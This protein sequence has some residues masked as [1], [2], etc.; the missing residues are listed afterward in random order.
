M[1]EN[2]VRTVYGIA[3]QSAK[4]QGLPWAMIPFTTLN[5]K[6][7]IQSGVLPD[8]GVY[9]NAQF[10]CIGNGGHTTKIGA[11]G[12]ALLTPQQ[13]EPTNASLY[14]MLPFVLCALGADLAPADRAKYGL[15]RIENH[16][17]VNYIAYYL[18]RLDL[19]NVSVQMMLTTVQGGVSNSTPFV[20]DSS[21]LN[22]TPPV[23]S[24]SGVNTSNGS[25]VSA[26]APMSIVFDAVDTQ[27][28]LNVIDIIY[29]DRDYAM[30][31]EVAICSG[32]NKVVQVTDPGG[33]PFNM[34][35]VIAC[36]VNDFSNAA[37]ALQFNDQGAV[38]GLDIGGTEP[39]ITA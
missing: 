4:Q 13:F 25:Y 1:A 39:L 29:Q 8:A 38:I 35:E 24:N 19:T 20:P 31:S 15:R 23:I 12:V 14:N 32:V 9:P 6:L 34:N 21:N 7:G 17:G 28:F 18:K 33:T 26:S 5:E 3:L 27:R 37:I 2:T 10:W 36:Q 30:I 16:N 22:P 11:G